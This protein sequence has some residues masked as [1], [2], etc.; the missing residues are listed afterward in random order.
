MTHEFS[1]VPYGVLYRFI[2]ALTP[3]L[4]KSEFWTHGKASID[5]II[6]FLYTGQ[7]TLWVLYD[8]DPIAVSVYVIT[9]IK[10][11][12]QARMLVFQYCA[13]DYGALANAGDLIFTALEQYAR[14]TGCSGIE[15]FGRPGWGPYAKKHGCTVKTVVY[16]KYFNEVRP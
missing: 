16:E 10:T 9:E 2:P 7:M 3:N 14:H 11:Y 8:A 6:R 12:P 1:F 5:D 15:F 4:A 13:G